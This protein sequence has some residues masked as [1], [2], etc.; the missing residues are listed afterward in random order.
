MNGV[1]MNLLILS[2][3]KLLKSSFISKNYF[4]KF[5]FKNLLNN[6]KYEKFYGG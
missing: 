4:Q 6:E 2:F 3:S 1:I 5:I